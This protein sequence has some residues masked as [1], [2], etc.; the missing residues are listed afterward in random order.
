VL[1][2]NYTNKSWAFNE[3]SITCFGYYQKQDD[4]TWQNSPQTWESSINTWA[5]APLESR[6]RQIIAGNQEGFLFIINPDRG[7]TNAPALQITKITQTGQIVAI[8]SIDH[9]LTAGEFIKIENCYG[10]TIMNGK[11]YKINSWVD[12]DN[13]TVIEPSFVGTYYGRG[14]I[15]RVSNINILTKQY[16]FYMSQGRNAY[17]SKVDFCVDKTS[18]GQVTIDAFTGSSYNSLLQFGKISGALLGTNILETS[19][20]T[21]YSFE[22]LQERL[23]HPIYLQAD[24]ECIQLRIYMNDVQMTDVDIAE[25]DFEL[26]AMTFY[27]VPTSSRM[28]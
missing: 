1:V 12:K 10:A 6:F 23:W 9:N 19:P 7:A 4:A 13:F 26:N 21:M 11:I 27:A 8:N 3:D 5:G 25:S 28:Q 2:Y 14:T 18:G 20:Y 22:Q 16:N 15:A 17:I 24:G